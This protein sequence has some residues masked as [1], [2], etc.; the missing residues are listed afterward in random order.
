MG[1]MAFSESCTCMYTFER[2]QKTDGAPVERTCTYTEWVC[3]G[4]GACMHACMVVAI[5][6]GNFPIHV[7]TQTCKQPGV[8]ISA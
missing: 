6:R 4:F 3:L 7:D 2:L 1:R 8:A 5:A